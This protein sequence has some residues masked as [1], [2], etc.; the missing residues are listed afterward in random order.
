[1]KKNDRIERLIE[2]LTA[3]PDGA[4]PTAANDPA[5]HP[6][7]LGYFECFQQQR[8]YEAHDVLEHLWLQVKAEKA[9][10]MANFYKALIQIAGAFVHLRQ[11]Y[12]QPEH[13]VHGRRLRPAARLLRLAVGYLEPFG[14]RCLRLDVAGVCALC[15]RWATAVESHGFTINPWSPESAPNLQPLRLETF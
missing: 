1:M 13:R 7:Y 5:A 15:E 8:Y 3:S 10:G 14:P 9:D 2:S 4:R 12:E 11:Q 6:C